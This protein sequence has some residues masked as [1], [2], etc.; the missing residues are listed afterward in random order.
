MPSPAVAS[1]VSTVRET[2]AEFI[3]HDS[4]GEAAAL[5]FYTLLSLAPLLLIVV[6]VAGL[7][8][9]DDAATGQ[10]STQIG[11]M[12]GPEAAGLIQTVLANA[13]RSGRGPAAVA[14][15]VL[16][17]LLGATSGLVR[18]KSALNR[19]FGVPEG[20]GHGALWRFLHT[21]L[22]SLVIVL[23]VGLLLVISLAA[24]AVLA[25]LRQRLEEVM[26]GRFSGWQWGGFLMWWFAVGFLIALI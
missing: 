17:L 24:D 9:G 1:L 19:V 13:G 7:V 20:R 2:T 22:V 5:S 3:D 4:L 6:G 21:R 14:F 18:L 26:P 10:L 12:V 16:T 25:G 11:R 15:G 23:A 8:W